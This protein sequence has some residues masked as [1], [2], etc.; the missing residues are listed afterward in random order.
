MRAVFWSKHRITTLVFG[1]LASNVL[2]NSREVRI[3]DNWRGSLLIS[4]GALTSTS[5]IAYDRYVEVAEVTLRRILRSS[6]A[7]VE[8]D[9]NWYVNN[10]GDVAE[11]I[12]DGIFKSARDHFLS[13]GYFEDRLPRKTQ[14]DTAWYIKT[15]PDVAEAIKRGEVENAQLHFELNGF[16]EGRLPF[17]GWTLSNK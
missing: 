14:V 17:E 5:Q 6:L 2:R 9:E 8:V 12:T 3:T 11:A 4:Y 1:Q 16:R 7:T 13:A 15:Y 10:Y